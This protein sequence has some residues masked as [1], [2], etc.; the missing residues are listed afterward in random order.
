MSNKKYW[1][2]L[3][4]LNNTPAY[5]EKVTN[6]F[7]N[8]EDN[9]EETGNEHSR[10]DFLKAMGF[11]VSIA[12]VASACQIPV[13]HAIPY[14]FDLR[15]QMPEIVPGVAEYFATSY[16]DSGEFCSVLV[17]N[18][19]G[20]PIKVEGNP[21]STANGG[22]NARAQAMLLGLYD[23]TRLHNP[24][25]KNEKAGW[26]EFDAEIVEKLDKIKNSN[27]KVVIVTNTVLSTITKKAIEKFKTTYP[28]TTVVAYDAIS[29][30]AIRKA[31]GGIIPTYQFDKAD[32]IVGF[33]CDFLGTWMN[34]VENSSKYVVN[35]VPSKSNPK[36]SKHF[37]FQSTMTITGASADYKYPIKPSEEKQALINLYNKIGGSVAAAKSIN[38]E[39]DAGVDKVAKELLANKGKSIVVSGTN[40]A[41]IQS[42]INGI[43]ASLTN[44]G[45]T[46]DTNNTLNY[47]Q[48]NDEE[49]KTLV[50]D[51]K[52]GAYSG[53]ILLGA[54]PVYD[55][56]SGDVF[57]NALQK[58]TLSVSTAD[59]AD[60]SAQYCTYIAPNS[61]ILES[62]DVVEPKNGQFGF[63]QPTITTL[64]DTRQEAASLLTWSG[65]NST[66]DTL[67]QSEIASIAGTDYA[68]AL[69]KG[70]VD[71]TTG[72]GGSSLSSTISITAP[73][74]SK[75]LEVIFYE[76]VGIGDGKLANNPFLQEMPDPI[77][78]ATWDNYILVP[79]TF[80]K[81]KGID[82]MPSDKKVPVAKVTVSGKSFELPVVVQ[83]GQ[84]QNT[85][86]IALGYGREK[87]GNVGSGVGANVY[88]VL[89]DN[90]YSLDNATFELTGKTYNLGLNQTY[91]S[92][93]EDVSL[94][95]K[96]L[97]Y[98]G[99]VVK[100]T[101]LSSYI[102]DDHA[103][104]EDRA[105]I[106]KHMVTMYPTPKFPGHHWG[107]SVD[108][109]AC[110]GCGAC[111]VACNIE[112]N[113]PVV[114]R[115][116][117]FRSQE[118]HWLRID[119]YYNG[120]PDNPDVSF[121]PMMCQHCDNAP[122]ENV[123][124]VN[125]T[126]HS[127][128]GVNQ[129]AYNRCIGTRYCANNCP[130][131]VRRFNWLDYQ[132]NDMFG[133]FNDG[134]PGWGGAETKGYM[135]DSLTRMILNPDVVARTR[136]VIEKCSFCTQ[137]IQEGKLNAKKENRKLADGEIKTAC[138]TACSTNAIVFGDMNDNDSQVSKIFDSGRNYFLFEEQHFLAHV[139][140]QTKIRNK[141]EAP[142]R[143]F[144]EQEG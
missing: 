1:T 101:N 77:S 30:Y 109:N 11:S 5:I 125:A 44:F 66:I 68:S 85:L 76:K 71:K 82:A 116:Q 41:E 133:E 18:R 56:A 14:T 74:S 17:K 32:V 3:E 49:L 119:R 131:K 37:Q 46:I 110:T 94:P 19:E 4:E 81:E 35:R 93:M 54:N 43:N 61:H 64:F 67:V 104:N 7:N 120:N 138:Q 96:P 142:Q 24:L 99:M 70:F 25:R 139:G 113:V 112:N 140:Y 79:Y 87:A 84:A 86:A 63:V 33:N 114:G 21:S 117:V 45:T 27:E 95:G 75:G 115:R 34:P 126:N 144:I 22:T 29:Q 123:C 132:G 38:K 128:E 26:K 118:M 42:L 6:E 8:V 31:S 40:D 15:N 10:R 98:R 78:K 108:M 136:G 48:G 65:D 90:K 103:G 13:K 12:A 106:L 111:V 55:T 122:C 107:M 127:T 73:Q 52:A 60:E 23:V 20:R 72:V 50:A 39:V 58:A 16:F 51:L 141:D 69:Q 89:K 105:D 47:K 130:F 100:E 88:G 36:M 134:T 80:A 92:L 57:K 129:M 135:F 121:Q 97:K 143:G 102:K 124:P 2:S 83:F 59:R 28:N 9:V 62:W 137:R 91:H 53:I